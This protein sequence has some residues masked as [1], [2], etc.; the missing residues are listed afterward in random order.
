MAL[1]V[2]Y[3]ALALVVSFFCSLLEAAL[4]STTPS[5]VSLLAKERPQVAERLKALKA[6]LDRP[7][8]A[9]LTLNTFAHTLGAAGA[10]A[11]AARLYGDAFL[12]VFSFVLTLLILVGTEIIPKTLGATHW[13]GLAP[14]VTRVLPPMI[15]VMYPFVWLSQRLSR[16]LRRGEGEA[17]AE[18]MSRDEFVAMADMGAE[19]GAIEERERRILEHLLLFRTLH[20][21]DVMTPRTVLVAYPEGMTVAEASQA[22]LPFSRIPV[23]ERDRDHVTGYVLE[24][25]VLGAL[26]EGRGAEPLAALR[27]DVLS[28]PESLPLPDL[29]DRLLARRQHL[30]LVVDEYGGTAGVATMEDVVETLLGLEIL[31]E[32]DRA[33]DMQALARARWARRSARMGMGPDG[34]P[35][36]ADSLPALLSADPEAAGEMIDEGLEEAMEWTSEGG[37]AERPRDVPEPVEPEPDEPPPAVREEATAWPDERMRRDA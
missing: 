29:F 21:H 14:F 4:L 20:V 22:G 8:A 17:P 24:D 7:L 13:R 16:L 35:H 5:Y 9:I 25:D 6:D 30:A 26:A 23:Y 12:G 11:Q 33:T 37:P 28:V 2:L 36:A 34:M 10:G 27:R 31:D 3:V 19:Q 18:T 32:S 15:A 1:L